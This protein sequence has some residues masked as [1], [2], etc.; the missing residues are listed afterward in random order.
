VVIL[1]DVCILCSEPI[2]RLDYSVMLPTLGEVTLSYEVCRHCRI[3]RYVGDGAA[4]EVPDDLLLLVAADL[5][6]EMEDGDGDV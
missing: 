4:D 3:F 2:L 6:A 1:A 5:R